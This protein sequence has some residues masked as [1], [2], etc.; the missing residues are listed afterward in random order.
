MQAFPTGSAFLC[1]GQTAALR[2]GAGRGRQQRVRGG[3][4]AQKPRPRRVCASAPHLPMPWKDRQ[5]QVSE[6]SEPA[7]RALGFAP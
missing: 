2:A 4:T 1:P 7:Q 6:A 5:A 3:N